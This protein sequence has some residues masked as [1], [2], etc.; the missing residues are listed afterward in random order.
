MPSP[1]EEPAVSFSTFLISLA[2]SALAHLGHGEGPAGQPPEQDLELA[3]HTIGLIDL[4][5]VKTK[6]NLDADEQELLAT[7]QKELGEKIA[8]RA[9]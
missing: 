2:S 1:S 8:A 9:G 7:L 5:A 6:G 3:R 4:L